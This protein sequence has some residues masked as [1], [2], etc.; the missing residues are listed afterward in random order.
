MRTDITPSYNGNETGCPEYDKIILREMY[1]RAKAAF[2]FYRRPENHGSKTAWEYSIVA[3][4]R[5]NGLVEYMHR[6]YCLSDA[7]IESI[8]GDCSFTKG[9][10]FDAIPASIR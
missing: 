6:V 10:V 4:E 5:F 3:V 8:V 9:R 7:D 1:D 2:E